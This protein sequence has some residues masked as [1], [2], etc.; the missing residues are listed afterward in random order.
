METTY[1]NEPDVQVTSSTVVAPWGVYR[2]Q[3]IQKVEYKRQFGVPRWAV[4]GMS[5][6]LLLSLVATI[7]YLTNQAPL[8]IPP[9]VLSIPLLVWSALYF[10][11]IWPRSTYT[12]VMKGV[13]GQVT[14]NC[15]DNQVYALK[16]TSALKRLLKEHTMRAEN[17][18]GAA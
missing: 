18:S 5:L 3:D 4:R 12:V 13:F 11:L 2:T 1:F 17:R 6:L 7:F 10:F 9:N 16:L 15:G 14:F 8:G